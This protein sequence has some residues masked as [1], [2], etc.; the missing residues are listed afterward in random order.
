MHNVSLVDGKSG[1]DTVDNSEQALD[2]GE[3]EPIVSFAGFLAGQLRDE[4]LG[5]FVEICRLRRC[6]HAAV[7]PP[8]SDL[9]PLYSRC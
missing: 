2:N 8:Q 1:D 6:R 7:N 5:H 9:R 4:L 3:G